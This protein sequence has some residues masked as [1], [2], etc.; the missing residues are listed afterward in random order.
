MTTLSAKGIISHIVY[1]ANGKLVARYFYDGLNRLVRQD[2]INFGT[3]TYKYDHAGNITC[4]TTYALTFDETLGTPAETQE[5]T[6]RQ[7]GWQDQLVTLNGQSF[8]YDA[9]GNP[10]LYCGKAMTWQGRRLLSYNGSTFTY[11]VNGMRTT[12]AVGNVTIAYY[13]DD[14]NLVAERRTTDS[15]SSWLY[16]LYGVDGIAGFRYNNTTYLFRK[17]IQG[18]VT[19][20]YTESGTL[21]G[22][23]A[24]DAWGNCA[25]LQ[26]T[27]GIATLNPFRYRGYYY[28]TETELYYLKSRYYDPK[29]GRFISPDDISYL[30]PETIGGLNLYAYCLNNPIM[31]VDPT[32]HAPWWSWFISG[33]QVLAGIVLCFVPGTQGIGVGLI[34]GGGLGLISNAVS[35]AIGQ[36]IGGDSSIAN[37]W[38]AFSTGMSILGLGV[39]GLIGGIA[40]MLV[41]CA[42][43]AFGAN[44]IVAAA[45]GTNYIQ[46]WAR[47]SDTAYGWTYFGLNLASSI[48][49]VAGNVYYLESVKLPRIGYDGKIN[50]FRYK[51]K[52]GKMFDFDYPHGNIRKNHFHGWNGPGLTGRTSGQHWNYLR[53]IWWLI[54]GR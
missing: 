32:G 47:M 37:G 31:Y 53:L 15:A 29:T 6:Y 21:V 30:D 36:A 9:I 46:Q 26:D 24:Y 34:V 41:G 27:N 1:N 43:M 7:R 4:K 51:T 17:N 22:Q 49:Q 12:K 39:P 10:T 54:S 25:T 40:L 13:Y 11:D 19:H 42:T 28:D 44:E 2:D 35:P 18:D 52:N 33:L 20:I 23:Y 45:T 14:G 3:V 38:G 8:E 50:G 48:G 5:Y 16:Y